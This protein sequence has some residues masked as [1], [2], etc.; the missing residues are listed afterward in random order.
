MTEAAL[1]DLQKLAIMLTEYCATVTK[2][3]VG[4][5]EI[6]LRAPVTPS[7]WL[8]FQAPTLEE[9]VGNAWFVV[10]GVRIEHG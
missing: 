7:R 8:T 9:A 5:F 10:S 6:D 2:R 4:L 3:R 1:T